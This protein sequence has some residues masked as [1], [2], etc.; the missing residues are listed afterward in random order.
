[1]LAIRWRPLI[2]LA[3]AVAALLV[4]VGGAVA[5]PL[6]A[7]SAP[8]EDAVTR[9]LRA[10]E[11]SESQY[12]LQR[13]LAIFDRDAVVRRF[14]DVAR[15]GPHDATLVLRDLALRLDGLSA[16]ERERAE[17]LFR[18]P[19]ALRP[20][21]PGQPELTDWIF[22]EPG[23]I[24]G[25]YYYWCTNY[26]V[27]WVVTSRDA[28]SVVDANGNGRSDY[29]DDVF[30]VMDAVWSTEIT[31]LGY[32]PP[33]SDATS[34]DGFS[35]WRTPESRPLFDI[36]ILDLVGKTGGAALGYCTTDDPNIL[37]PGSLYHGNDASAYCV[38]DNDYAEAWPR[39]LEVLEATAAHEFFHAVQFA[40]NFDLDDWLAEATATWVEDEVFDDVDDNHTYVDTS[41]VVW[42]NVPLDLERG[43]G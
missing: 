35:A 32:R 5:G 38:L 16:A 23:A 25:S 26:C 28:P 3:V 29:I 6:P 11:L 24:P 4:G 2:A 14:G 41:Q 42:P 19:T 15:P 30:Q 34:P 40:Y 43:R 13:A 12:A 20:D 9:A 7:L 31:V 27:N 1:M 8:P 33:K 37:E 17:L 18:R 21:D 10:G 36:Y 22:Y 39:E